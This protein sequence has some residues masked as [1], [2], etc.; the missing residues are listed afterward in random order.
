V[1]TFD[2]VFPLLLVVSVLRQVTGK[3]LTWFQFVW[4]IGL[5]VWATIE[6][7]RGFPATTAD[8]ILVASSAVLGVV[9]GA[10]AGRYTVIY[11]RADGAVMA[12]ATWA[13]V[14]LW[15][16]GTIGRL[17][18]GLYAEHGGGPTI[19]MF[20]AAHGL[21][22]NAWTAALTLMALAEVLGRTTTLAP[23]AVLATHRPAVSSRSASTSQSDDRRDALSGGARDWNSPGPSG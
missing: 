14:L 1:S 20:S 18:F 11:R 4:P 2:Y 22:V 6:Y 23:R 10:L 13:T 17:A 12:R 5:V 7:I 9:L 3:H 15:T 19:A 21:A 16:L 8:V